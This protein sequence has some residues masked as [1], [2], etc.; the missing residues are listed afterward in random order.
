MDSGRPLVGRDSRGFGMNL[1]VGSGVR[2]RAAL[3]RVVVSP[4]GS[5]TVAGGAASAASGDLDLGFARTSWSRRSG[6]SQ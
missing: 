6:S 3:V 5:L 4:A 2:R 1:V